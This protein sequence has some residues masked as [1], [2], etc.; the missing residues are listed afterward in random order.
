VPVCSDFCSWMA[1]LGRY[2]KLSIVPPMDRIE[3]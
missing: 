1:A 3:L 2:G